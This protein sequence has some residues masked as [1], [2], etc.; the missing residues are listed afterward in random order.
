MNQISSIPY[1][2]AVT[3]TAVDVANPGEVSFAWMSLGNNNA[4]VSYLQIFGIAAAS[5]TLGAT[6]PLLSIMIPA[7]SGREI[8]PGVR[9]IMGGTAFSIAA[10]TGPTNS[11]APSTA[12]DVN[13]GL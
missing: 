7:S 3:N 1:R 2:A 12:V 6:T 5:V 8:A 11:T 13:I 9:L 4:A 10:T